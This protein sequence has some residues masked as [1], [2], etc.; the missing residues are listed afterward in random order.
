MIS[1][2]PSWAH[3]YDEFWKTL[4]GRNLWFIKLR[5]GAVAMLLLVLFASDFIISIKFSPVQHYAILLVTFI[6]LG[7]NIILHYLRRYVAPKAESFNPIH[8]SLIQ[9]ILDII[10]LFILVYFTGS[11]ESPLFLLFAFHMI[12]GSLILPGVVVYS[13]AFCIVAVFTSLVLLEYNGVLFHHSVAGFLSFP[14]YQDFSYIISFTVLFG[15]LIFVIVLLTNR[16]ARQLY[17]N[18]QQLV[19]TI[20][21]LNRAEEE[22]QKYIIGVVHELKSPIAAVQSYIEMILQKYLGPL[23]ERV[24]QKLK[25]ARERAD[26]AIEMINNILKIS[27]LR[28]MSEMSVENIDISEILCSILDKLK[29]GIEAKKIN[30]KLTDDRL[31]R[32]PLK[33]DKFLIEM[34]ISNLLSNAVKYVSPGGKIDIIINESE[35]GIDLDISDNGVGIP[36][37]DQENIFKDFFRASNIKNKGYEGAGLGLSIVNQIVIRHGGRISVESPGRITDNELPG[38]TFKV[39][40]PFQKENN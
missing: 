8:H 22:K 2:I 33:G 19:E 1:L 36:A 39:F 12:I 6:I 35:A 21:R 29:G 18:E 4:R 17:R 11:I 31:L 13:I 30:V 37:K 26:E 5:Y 27:R 15:F 40:I 3:H 25:S 32:T 38:C 16:I 14:V 34:A 10:A 20:E 28:L 7:Y 9:M 23:D 24:E